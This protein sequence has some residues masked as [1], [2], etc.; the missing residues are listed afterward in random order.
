MFSD[1]F[2]PQGGKDPPPQLRDDTTPPRLS[3]IFLKMFLNLNW[4]LRNNAHLYTAPK[5]LSIPPQF[6]I[7][8]NNT[9]YIAPS[10]AL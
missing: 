3:V 7:P 2:T 5:H 4:G 1:M 10:L 9:D 6:Q 8:R